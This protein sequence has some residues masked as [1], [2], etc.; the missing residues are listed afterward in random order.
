MKI[1]MFDSGVGGLT[2]L[3]SVYDKYPNNE[4]IYIGDNK[5]SPYGD[6][7]KEEL[8]KYATRIIDYFIKQD[9]KLI[10]I[11]CNT[12]CS[13]ILPRLKEKYKDITLIGVIDSTINSFIKRD[14]KNVLVIATNKTISSNVYEYKIKAINNNIKVYSLAT[15]KLV[16][17]IE[18]GIDT[19]E[20]LH[21]Y[22]EPY[23]DIDS[24]ILGCTH[25]KIIEDKIDKIVE[26]INSSD[27]VV[28][29]LDN[30]LD[31][32]GISKLEIYT[33]GNVLEFNK[34]C[35]KI[36]GQVGNYIDL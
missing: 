34:L 22:F 19:R 12:I 23:K 18:M 25:Y 24:I 33:T 20:T 11:A 32:N 28:E 3:K 15:P 4:Y 7:T 17:M 2:V 6:K 10:V 29:E 26:I 9:I 27:G 30:I 31:N 16:P 35:T 14:K 1:G 13:N 5:N 8:Y 36:I 21:K